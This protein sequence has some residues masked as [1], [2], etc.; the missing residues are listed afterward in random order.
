MTKKF[1]MTIPSIT[2]ADMIDQGWLVPPTYLSPRE[3]DV[4]TVVCGIG[5]T[6]VNPY[7]QYCTGKR[8][9]V[10]CGT[11]EHCEVVNAAFINARVPAASVLAMQNRAERDA[12]IERFKAGD[13]MVLTTCNVLIDSKMP[14]V[15]VV[16]VANPTGSKA[17]YHRYVASALVPRVTPDERLAPTAEERRAAIAASNK[18]VAMILDVA[19]N[20]LRLGTPD[21]P[22]AARPKPAPAAMVEINTADLT[23]PALRYAMASAEG[24]LEQLRWCHSKDGV[25]IQNMWTDDHGCW[26]PLDWEIG[27]PLLTKYAIAF[28]GKSGGADGNGTW[29]AY[30]SEGPDVWSA[31]GDQ[32]LL[33]ACRAIVLRH[34]GETV[35]VPADIAAA[36]Q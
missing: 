24:L 2:M 22:P 4:E 18:P 11:V 13:L 30:F 7:I 16:I 9:I 20:V 21:A 19:G 28:E 8:A 27:G 6:I 3:E 15:D 34:L 12:N 26:D 10:F 35:K 25:G 29:M 32:H 1:V 17:K 36:K 14:E 23:G 33:A 31:D 5:H